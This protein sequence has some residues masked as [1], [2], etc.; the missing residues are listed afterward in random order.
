MKTML[1]MFSMVILLAG[2][3]HRD[4]ISRIVKTESANEYFGNGMY[5]LIQ[6]PASASA[7][8]VASRALGVS[9]TN[10]TVLETRQV[11]I[12]TGSKLPPEF[13]GYTAALVDTGSSRKVVLLQ[14]HKDGWWSQ[15]YDDK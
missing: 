7:S 15:V 4:P 9:V 3:G 6:L 2:C 5:M 10:I 11:Q 1:L 12:P 13:V 8:E 14:F